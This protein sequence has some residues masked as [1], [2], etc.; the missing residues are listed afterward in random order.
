MD[1]LDAGGKEECKALAVPPGMSIMRRL[2]ER[3]LSESLVACAAERSG[4]PSP[5]T[6]T[7][8]KKMWLKVIFRSVFDLAHFSIFL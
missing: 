3:M 6:C 8:S 7:Y 2:G 1:G 4:V 5:M